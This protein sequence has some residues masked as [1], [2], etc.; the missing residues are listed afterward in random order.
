MQGKKK[1]KRVNDSLQTK[2]I[3]SFCWSIEQ[4]KYL[5]EDKPDSLP[6]LFTHCYTIWPRAKDFSPQKQIPQQHMR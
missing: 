5:H 1:N 6:P 2:E 3:K 4:I